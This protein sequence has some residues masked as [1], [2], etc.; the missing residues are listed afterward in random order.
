M[1][2]VE[3]PKKWDHE[4]DVI[5]V[6]GGTAGLP[7]AIKVAEAGFK[8][9]V[10]ETRKMLG[11]SFRMVWG[12]FA[13]A[14][15]EEQKKQGVDDSPEILY[16][17]MVKVSGADPEVAR[18]YAD[19]QIEAYKMLKEE[20]IVFPG[21]TQLPGH[22]RPR[23]LGSLTIGNMGVKM[24]KAVEDRAR[25][26]GVE[27]LPEHRAIRLITDLKTGRVVGVQVDVQDGKE[28]KNF[29]AKKAVI[30]ASGGFGRNLELVAEF[31]PEMVHCVPV[32]PPSHMGDGLIMG[33]AVGA[34]TK[35]IGKAV[36]PAWPV[37][38]VTHSNALRALNFGGIMVNSEGQR[39]ADESYPDSFYGP[40]T[41]AGMRQSGGSYFV[42]Y[43]EKTKENIIKAGEAYGKGGG[44]DFMLA[45]ER[46]KQMKADTIEEL[47]KIAGI[48][49]KGLKQTINKYNTDIDKTGYDTVFG[50]KVQKGGI[51]TPLIKL[52]S[53]P[54]YAVRCVTSTT[55]MKGGLKINGRCQ[56]VNQFGEVIPG[57]YAAGEVSGGLHSKTYL[58]GVM[59][60]GSFTQ[61]II[62]GKN[63]IKEPSN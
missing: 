10:L 17:D 24:A 54:Y 62:A 61:G 35:D 4:S 42:V 53:G 37:D 57:L 44:Q 52:D 25:R 14:G 15:T 47:G 46:C 63:A 40:M 26:V 27:I 36:A 21:N 13:I 56:V 20:G 34:A 48:D 39:F 49:G 16:Q 2:A 6:G 51:P 11:G 32:M 33:L 38:A 22:S 3:I 50:R 45:L 18:A 30:I 28:K 58:L 31:A 1:S 19:N 23:A 12:S 55:S 60:A 8:A 7:A 9:T 5:V 43:T 59:S 29:K 41:G